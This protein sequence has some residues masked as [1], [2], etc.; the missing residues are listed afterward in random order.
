MA[1]EPVALS[2][3]FGLQELDEEQVMTLL[4]SEEFKPVRE[5]VASA[6][7]GIPVPD[8]FFKEMIREVSELLD[9]DVHAIL[10]SAW[11]VSKEFRKYLKKNSYP[12]DE[13][14]LVPLGEHTVTSKHRPSLKPT[15]GKIPLK[16]VHFNVDLALKLDGV[17]LKMRNGRIMAVTIGFC[18]AEGDVMF[19]SFKLAEKKGEFS[20]LLGTIELGDGI[21][22]NE[23]GSRVH[24][25]IGLVNKS[26]RLLK[27][28]TKPAKAT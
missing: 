1:N 21:P 26:R 23:P 17:I 6:L 4:E 10:L 13:T 3:L 8:G 15:V 19:G 27:T 20:Q 7:K 12:P 5:N 2:E 28:E 11:G 25:V 16:E 14:V 24:E 18:E 9:I 22:I